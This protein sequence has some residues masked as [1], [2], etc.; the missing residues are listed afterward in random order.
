MRGATLEIL[1]LAGGA[2]RRF[3][4][5][6]MHRVDGVPMLLR[7]YEA[8]KTTGRHVW[9][10][11]DGPLPSGVDASIDAPL[12]ID[13]VPH[14]G[15]LP[16]VCDA[17]RA[18]RCDYVFVAAADMPDLPGSIVERLAEAR[19][20][21]DEAVVPVHDGSIEPLAALY[22]RSAVLDAWPALRHSAKPSMHALIER[23][24]TRFVPLP[25]AYFTN[26]NRPG[27]IS[28]RTAL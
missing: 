23:L 9:I 6:L 17:C 20:P 12:L 19:R 15:P 22:R 7:T 5:K 1:L 25:A 21:A 10:L 14:R 16:A 28:A 13:R 11:A 18:V 4:G 3:P 26:V 24:A 27:D 8:L 2:A